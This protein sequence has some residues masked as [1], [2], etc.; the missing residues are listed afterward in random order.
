M[1]YAART[2]LTQYRMNI[3]KLNWFHRSLKPHLNNPVR[4][5]TVFVSV[6]FGE[7]ISCTIILALSLTL[8]QEG[9]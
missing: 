1:Y 8:G 5:I 7:H 2:V 9:S 6:K 4:I 3:V